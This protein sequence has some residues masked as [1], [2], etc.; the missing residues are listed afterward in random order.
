MAS[1]KNPTIKNPSMKILNG[2]GVSN[3]DEFGL[4]KNNKAQGKGGKGAD[5]KGRVRRLEDSAR[6][7][8]YSIEILDL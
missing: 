5:Q 1:I 8:P 6:V 4:S 7:G 2:G 3:I